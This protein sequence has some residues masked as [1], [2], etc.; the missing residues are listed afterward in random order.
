MRQGAAPSI[1]VAVRVL[2][3]TAFGD[4]SVD[5]GAAEAA[6]VSNVSFTGTIEIEL[7]AFLAPHELSASVLWQGVSVDLRPMLWAHLTRHGDMAK[8]SL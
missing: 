2:G 5:V 7:D 1:H 3:K 4:E 6:G 8:P